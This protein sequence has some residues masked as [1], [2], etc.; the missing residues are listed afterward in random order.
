VYYDF[1]K[2]GYEDANFIIDPEHWY[3]AARITRDGM[4]RVSYGVP[5]GCSEG[6]LKDQQP[7]KWKKMLPGSPT[8]DMYRI[9]NF[10][11]YKIHQRLVKSMREGPFLLAADAAHCKSVPPPFCRIVL[12]IS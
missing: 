9:T 11:P 5:G 12:N 6:E 7:D 10:S 1:Y 8:P 2:Y 3:L 4:W